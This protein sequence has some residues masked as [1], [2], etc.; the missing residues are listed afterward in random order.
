[1]RV[2][3]LKI[4]STP[5]FSV[6]KRILSLVVLGC[7]LVFFS[8]VYADGPGTPNDPLGDHPWDELKSKAEHQPPKPPSTADMI[9]FPSPKLGSWGII[10]YAPQVKEHNIE[11]DGAPIH[12][13]SRNRGQFFIFF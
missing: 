11:K 5:G 1:M 13:S 2:S 12:P 6:T 8:L 7:I 9:I 3:N 4:S 10:I